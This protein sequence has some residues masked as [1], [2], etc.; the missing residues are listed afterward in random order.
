MDS[1]ILIPLVLLGLYAV[2][3]VWFRRASARRSQ[4]TPG[5]GRRPAAAGSQSDIAAWSAADSGLDTHHHHH[6]GAGHHSW[7]D[8]GTGH[9]GSFGGHDGGFGGHSGGFGGHHG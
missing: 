8:G 9:H 7:H 2:G 3:M 6:H 4:L 1:T 5:T